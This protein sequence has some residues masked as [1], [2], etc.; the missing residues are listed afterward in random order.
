MR[1]AKSAS[2][3]RRAARFSDAAFLSAAVAATALIALVALGARSWIDRPFPGFFLRADRTIA[4]VG[5]IAWSDV[6]PGRLYDRTLLAIDGAPIADSGALHRLVAAKPI[7]STFAYTLTDGRTTET[8]TI[9]SRRF[10]ASDYWA[11]F[12][13]YLGSGL[14][15]V[16]LAIVAAW[17]LP[18]DRLGRSLVFLGS[19]GGL[20]MLSSA[21]LYPPAVSHRAHALATTLLPPTLLQF[22]LA[23]GDAR[24]R[25]ARWSVPAAWTLAVAA[26]VSMQL[27][28]G[29]PAATGWIYATC[30]A[31]LGCALAAAAIGLAARVRVAADAAP[32]VAFTAL[33]GLGVPAVVF[34]VGGTLGGIPQNA[35]ATLTFLFPLGMLATLYRDRT[36]VAFRRTHDVAR[37]ARSL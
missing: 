13:A 16:L 26:A 5:R 7:G 15:F 29:D 34:L 10:V 24:G 21:D 11:V 2:P 31:A 8:V 4:A 3:A 17:A 25:F 22:A 20:Y 36:G 28:L 30:N 14:C 27:L 33:F 32:L 19:I 6:A 37:A 35:S 12:G 9:P 18:A 1:H 23:I